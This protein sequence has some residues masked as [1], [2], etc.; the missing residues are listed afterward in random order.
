ML[1]LS[2]DKPLKETIAVK[3]S[4]KYFASAR[5]F[6]NCASRTFK[7]SLT[8]NND[9]STDTLSSLRYG[10]NPSSALII[11]AAVSTLALSKLSVNTLLIVSV[12]FVSPVEQYGQRPFCP[13]CSYPCNLHAAHLETVF[14]SKNGF[15]SLSSSGGLKYAPLPSRIPF[16]PP[17][18]AILLLVVN[19]MVSISTPICACKSTI[20]FRPVIVVLIFVKASS[21]FFFAS[22]YS[23]ERIRTSKASLISESG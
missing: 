9:T 12:F 16:A 5:N 11:A 4:C 3:R 7:S 17:R 20:S 18:L 6:V 22:S 15:N 2:T 1:S 10:F 14:S 13:N 21:I 19:F 8:P 23:L